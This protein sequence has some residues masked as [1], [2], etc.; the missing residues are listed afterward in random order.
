MKEA[1]DFLQ[2]AGVFYLATAEGGAASCASYG[3]HNGLRRK[4][5]FHDGQHYGTLQTACGESQS[6]NYCNR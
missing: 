4:I 3:L 2:K 5:G 6:R 1:L